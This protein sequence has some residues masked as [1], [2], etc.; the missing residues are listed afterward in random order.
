M[1]LRLICQSSSGN[2]AWTPSRY[3]HHLSDLMPATRG[4]QCV[5]ST[6]FG[7]GHTKRN[8]FTLQ[9]RSLLVRVMPQAQGV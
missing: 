1:Q 5:Q 9:D 4:L 3:I 7:P 6:R 2:V 8:V